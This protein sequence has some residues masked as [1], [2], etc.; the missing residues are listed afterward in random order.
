M[1]DESVSNNKLVASLLPGEKAFGL[2]EPI[3]VESGESGFQTQM[4]FSNISV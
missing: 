2:L 4:S 1:S 3:S